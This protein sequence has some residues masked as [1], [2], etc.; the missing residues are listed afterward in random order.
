MA[1]WPFC[2]T[3]HF[4]FLSR[5]NIEFIQ[6]AWIT[7]RASLFGG[8]LLAGSWR[9]T[10]F[11]AGP[12]INRSM[13]S[14]LHIPHNFGLCCPEVIACLPFFF[15]FLFLFFCIFLYSLFGNWLLRLFRLAPNVCRMTDWLKEFV[16]CPKAFFVVI[17]YLFFYIHVFFYLFLLIIL[18][19]LSSLYI[20]KILFC[21]HH[22][23]YLHIFS[24][25]LESYIYQ[26]K[27]INVLIYWNP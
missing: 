13:F 4:L 27:S 25:A 20:S 26:V 14:N 10:E 5:E 2:I 15:S 8:R 17:I 16:L 12:K 21:F 18:F 7:Y 22:F 23:H 11:T 9:W 1:N 3:L 19:S 6:G 24:K